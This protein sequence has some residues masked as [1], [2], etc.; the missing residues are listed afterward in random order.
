MSSTMIITPQQYP[1]LKREIAGIATDFMSG[2]EIEISGTMFPVVRRI[3]N[4]NGVIEKVLV[5]KTYVRMS[6]QN[7]YTDAIESA[8]VEKDSEKL[9]KVA[10][11]IFERVGTD[12]VSL[13]GFSDGREKASE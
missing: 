9:E 5:A 8:I 11:R 7:D 4:T 2:D 13:Y 1:T 3:F 12:L 6:V 10:K